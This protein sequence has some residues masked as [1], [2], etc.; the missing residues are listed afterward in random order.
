MPSEEW[1]RSWL[2]SSIHAATRTRA[3]ALVAKCS[4]SRN[5]N[6][7]VECQLSMTALSSAEP[8]RPIDWVIPTRAQAAWKFLAVY[9][10]P[11]SMCMITPLEASLPPRTATAICS[12]AGSQVGVVVLAQGEPDDPPRAHVQHR[13][14]VELA[15]VGGD[16]GAI[17]IPL[18]V[19]PIGAEVPADQVRCPPPAP[20]LP[21]GLPA[22]TLGPGDQTELAHQLRDG[23]L[24]DPPTLIA[25]V[26]GDPRRT[27]GAPML[28]EQPPDL[29][30]QLLPAS[31]PGRGVA[32]APLVEPRLGHRQRPTGGRLRDVVLRPL[33]GDEPGHRYRPIASSTQRATERLRPPM[34]PTCQAATGSA[35]AGVAW[36][37]A[38]AGS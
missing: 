22:F 7:T 10:L 13:V 11:W 6:S 3:W 14:E 31:V 18:V 35:F 20:A 2:Y 1:R 26:R 34:S 8:A 38:L 19:E 29:D 9:S 24:A 16:L 37:K 36:G 17:A 4:S 32:V 30:L 15:L 27:V 28:G 23:V 12:A 25:Q 21:G 33:G 5:S